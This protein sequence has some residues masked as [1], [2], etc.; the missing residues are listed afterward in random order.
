MRSSPYFPFLS[1]YPLS[2]SVS[3][4]P[5]PRLSLEIDLV[6]GAM[7]P[8]TIAIER[9]LPEEEAL[10]AEMMSRESCC[11]EWLEGS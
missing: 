6:P 4:S 5:S 1:I 3:L 7:Y 11:V 9:V 8:V 10:G 2:L